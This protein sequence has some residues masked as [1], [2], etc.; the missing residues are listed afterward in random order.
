MIEINQT[1]MNH[2]CTSLLWNSKT[3]TQWFSSNEVDL[4]NV[5]TVDSSAVAFFIKW[6]KECSK[7]NEELI[8]YNAPQ[9]F[10]QLVNMYNVS[11]YIKLK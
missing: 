3:R 11:K 7:R 9:Q 4:K 2:E 10:I 5:V 8:C 6:A 1:T